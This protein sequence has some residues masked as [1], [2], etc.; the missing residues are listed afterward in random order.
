M[1]R[2]RKLQPSCQNKY[3][4]AQCIMPCKISAGMAWAL[5]WRMD[6]LRD[7]MCANGPWGRR[8]CADMSRTAFEVGFL[9]EE[10]DAF[11]I[12]LINAKQ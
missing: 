12:A 6:K 11:L 10:H 4:P 3:K 1:K 8:E 9:S 7:N 2:Q 5:S